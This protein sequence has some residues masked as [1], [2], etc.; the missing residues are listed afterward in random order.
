MKARE[1]L[2]ASPAL[3]VLAAVIYRGAVLH[4]HPFFLVLAGV[5]GAGSV[6]CV[7]RSLCS[8]ITPGSQKMPTCSRLEN[9]FGYWFNVFGWAG[10][11]LLML[12]IAWS[13]PPLH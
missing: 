3:A 6:M 13:I 8:G 5:A 11:Y 12:W 4:H 7:V 1:L 2:Y 10:C 9:P